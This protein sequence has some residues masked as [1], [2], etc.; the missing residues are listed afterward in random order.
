VSP[1]PHR[2]AILASGGGTNLQAIAEHF[3]SLGR[4]APAT[5]ALVVSDREGAGALER[6]RARGTEALYLPRDRDSHLLAELQ[7]RSITHIALA[8]YLRLVPADV[9]AFFRGRILNIHPALLPAFG[10]RGMYG[11]RVHEAVLAAG[12]RVSGATAHFVDE[13]Y[14][15]G[16]IA[17]QWPVP[18]RDGDSTESLSL[19][20]LRAEHRIYP[21]CVAALC[22]GTMHLELDGTVTGAPPFLFTRFVPAEGTGPDA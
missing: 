6:A 5:L 9:V 15:E 18:V 4:E 2:L 16:P 17:A 3:D 12:V 8:G 11:R 1:T 22:A 19:R 21:P 14:D 13:R 20:V 7:R 10:G